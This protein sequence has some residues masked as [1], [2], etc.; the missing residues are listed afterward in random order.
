MTR[1]RAL[2][3]AEREATSRC[4]R[5]PRLLRAGST[6]MP[7]T[8][9]P[10]RPR[11]LIELEVEQRDLRV[12][13]IDLAGRQI[14]RAE[15][16]AARRSARSRRRDSQPSRKRVIDRKDAGSGRRT[17]IGERLGMARE[18]RRAAEVQ[19]LVIGDVGCLLLDRED[20]RQSPSGGAQQ[21]GLDRQVA[22][23]LE[24]LPLVVGDLGQHARRSRRAPR[25]RPPRRSAARGSGV[26]SSGTRPACGHQAER[27]RVAA[28]GRVGDARIAGRV[29]EHGE[30]EP[31][32]AQGLRMYQELRLAVRTVPAADLALGM[33][34]AEVAGDAPLS[35]RT[36]PQSG[37]SASQP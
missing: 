20:T 11:R 4:R 25:S 33:D 1:R 6:P 7:P 30:P 16:A 28:E 34:H 27:R 3:P 12:K 21:V 19:D 37:L 8:P 35:S 10:G 32:P 2:P 31:L 17:A 36:T 9:K 23:V 26:W 15:K 22:M 13:E 18:Q 24:E 5:A 14:G 29:L